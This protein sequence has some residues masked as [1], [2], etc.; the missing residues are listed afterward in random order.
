MCT[1]DRGLFIVLLHLVTT[2]R[3]HACS[4]IA[5]ARHACARAHA[6]SYTHLRTQIVV[7]I[8]T[9]ARRLWGLYTPTHTD[10]GAYT[11]LRT[12]IVGAIHTYARRLWGP[13]AST[14]G[15]LQVPPPHPFPRSLSQRPSLHPLQC[16]SRPT[17]AQHDIPAPAKSLPS[18][19]WRD[20]AVSP[21]SPPCVRTRPSKIPCVRTHQEPKELLEPR[22][23]ATP[24]HPKEP[25]RA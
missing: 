5:C 18:P 24:R 21:P 7:P 3:V 23:S 14:A 9:Y 25:P 20:G 17:P 6:H 4:R 1:R 22:A 16:P 8:H 15:P 12:Q 2:P 13:R 10:C 19:P 11:H